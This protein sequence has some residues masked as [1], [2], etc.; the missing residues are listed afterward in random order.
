M[1]SVVVGWYGK[2]WWWWW[3][4]WWLLTMPPLMLLLLTNW[5]WNWNWNGNAAAAPA[6]VFGAWCC[7]CCCCF[8]CCWCIECMMWSGRTI[9]LSTSSSKIKWC[10]NVMSICRLINFLFF[11][12]YKRNSYD[13][14]DKW[15]ES[16]LKEK[17]KLTRLIE[18]PVQMKR[19]IKLDKKV[20]KFFSSFPL[21]LSLFKFTIAF[22]LLYK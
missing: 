5:N 16:E 14:L 20:R 11:L 7:C 18:H 3:W 9:P 2:W 15:S 17:L 4:W 10:V 13:S 21:S 12:Y 22:R 8:C 1:N 6:E 19:P